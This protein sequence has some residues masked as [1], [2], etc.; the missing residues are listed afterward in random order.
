[1]VKAAIPV[2][3]GTYMLGF[4]LVKSVVVFEGPRP[5]GTS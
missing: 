4:E 5:G 1:M 3:V 2:P